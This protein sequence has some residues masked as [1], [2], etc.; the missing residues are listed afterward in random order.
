MHFSSFQT[1]P[2]CGGCPVMA[3]GDVSNGDLPESFRNSLNALNF[4]HLPHLVPHIVIRNKIIQGWFF[5]DDPDHFK[6][7]RRLAVGQKNRAGLHGGDIDM[8]YPVFFFFPP[9]ILVFFDL[10]GQIIIHGRYRNKAVL[11]PFVHGQ[12]I[13]IIAGFFF[14]DQH[15]GCKPASDHFPGFFIDFRGIHILPFLKLSLCTIRV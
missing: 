2:D 12:R 5:R 14:P 13:E 7:I 10:S 8:P 15:A 6:K 4:I 11:C 3:V 1:D 9:R